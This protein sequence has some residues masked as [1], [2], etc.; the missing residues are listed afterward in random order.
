MPMM[1]DASLAPA[2]GGSF[3]RYTV[4]VRR[5]PPPLPR[6]ENEKARTEGPPSVRAQTA[7][8]WHGAHAGDDIQLC[9]ANLRT[10]PPT[11]GVLLRGTQR[12][13]LHLHPTTPTN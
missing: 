8:A 10:V 2:I 4:V 1:R 12:A 7:R 3:F 11:T 13:L 9:A 5:S 6:P